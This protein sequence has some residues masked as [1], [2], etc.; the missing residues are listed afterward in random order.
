MNKEDEK[1]L[2][3]M[4]DDYARNGHRCFVSEFFASSDEYIVC[5][6]PTDQGR[7]KL[8]ACHYLHLP[9]SEADA[10]VTT[11]QLT[12]SLRFML[13]QRLSA[14]EDQIDGSA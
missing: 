14:L 8:S 12:Q 2:F 4:L 10:I 3:K 13:D 7:S 11:K 9:V 5:F 1:A 6:R